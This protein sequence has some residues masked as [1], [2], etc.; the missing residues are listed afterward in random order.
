MINRYLFDKADKVIVLPSFASKG[1]LSPKKLLESVD[2]VL[3]VVL[4]DKVYIR[5]L[6][7]Y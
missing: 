2:V 6:P 7:L 4:L 1:S 5:G 3:L